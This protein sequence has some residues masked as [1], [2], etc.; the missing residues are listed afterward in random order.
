MAKPVAAIFTWTGAAERVG[1]KRKFDDLR[2]R[3][4]LLRMEFF[5]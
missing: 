1:V 4:F 3:G 2:T 5:V